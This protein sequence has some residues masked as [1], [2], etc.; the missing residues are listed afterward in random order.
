M[1]E[2]IALG[3]IIL[4]MWGSFFLGSRRNEGEIFSSSHNLEPESLDYDEPSQEE[5]EKQI[6]DWKRNAESTD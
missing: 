2:L 4:G 3:M 5:Y 6:D 1:I